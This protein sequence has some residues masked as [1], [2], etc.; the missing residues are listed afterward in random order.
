MACTFHKDVIHIRMIYD[1][2][3]SVMMFVALTADFHWTEDK[4]F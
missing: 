2:K 3:N 4:S 1:F